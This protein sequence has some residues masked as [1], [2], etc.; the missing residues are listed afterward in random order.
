MQKVLNTTHSKQTARNKNELC[1]RVCQPTTYTIVTYQTSTGGHLDS[2]KSY[3]HTL[4]HT[5][6]THTHARTHARTHTIAHTRT[7]AHTHAHTHARTHGNTQHT[8]D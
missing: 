6:H 7:H 5:I 8:H 4:Q 3:D 2:D 1:S